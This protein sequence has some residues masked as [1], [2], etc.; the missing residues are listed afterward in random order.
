MTGSL[1]SWQA[2]IGWFTIETI[3]AKMSLNS[4]MKN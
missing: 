3:G 1:R 4:F 2:V